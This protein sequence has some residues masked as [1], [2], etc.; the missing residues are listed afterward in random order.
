LAQGLVAASN[1]VRQLVRT[2]AAG[3]RLPPGSP[4]A[5]GW[6]AAHVLPDLVDV[7]AGRRSI[8]IANL[9][10]PAPFVYEGVEQR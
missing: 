6:R 7:L 9:A 1:D 3:D 4:L 2:H 10:G 8:R 5:R